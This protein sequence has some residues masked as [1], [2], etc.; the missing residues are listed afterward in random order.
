MSQPCGKKKK[1]NS[2]VCQ[3][4]EELHETSVQELRHVEFVQK[5]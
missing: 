3:G 5:T 1:S 2:K 4:E